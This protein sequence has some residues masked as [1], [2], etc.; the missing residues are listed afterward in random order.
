MPASGPANS[1][2]TTVGLPPK[3]QVD[4]R[5]EKVNHDDED[6]PRPLGQVADSSAR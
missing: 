3:D 6:G 5:P 4:D 1:S 2:E